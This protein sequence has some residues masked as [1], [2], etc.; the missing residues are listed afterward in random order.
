MRRDPTRWLDSRVT[1]R[2]E[3]STAS[4]GRKDDEFIPLKSDIRTSGTTWC[5]NATCYE[6]PTVRRVYERVADVTRV[7]LENF[8]CVA[9]PTPLPLYLLA[10]LSQCGR[11][12]NG[13][14][15]SHSIRYMQLLRYLPCAH[16]DPPDC[17]FYR[18][19]SDTIPKANRR[20]GSNLAR[21][22]A[23]LCHPLTRASLRLSRRFSSR[24]CSAARAC[25][26]SSCT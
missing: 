13:F 21:P 24:A 19:H 14:F 12:R 23:P 16:A 26:R 22:H 11:L 7:P 6:D 25:T 5:D 20:R 9:K 10:S 1:G 17:Q 8:E 2:F 15:R 4:G 18:R 3:R